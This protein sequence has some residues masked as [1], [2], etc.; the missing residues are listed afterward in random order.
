MILA[1]FSVLLDL[2]RGVIR[3]TTTISQGRGRRGFGSGSGDIR[4]YRCELTFSKGGIEKLN[5]SSHS[6]R[7]RTPEKFEGAGGP[8]NPGFIK[9]RQAARE[10]N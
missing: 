3:G 7:E 8:D 10:E 5:M 6:K 2:G 1:S 9:H 4:S